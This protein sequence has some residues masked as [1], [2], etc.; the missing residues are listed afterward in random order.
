[1]AAPATNSTTRTTIIRRDAEGNVVD[2]HQSNSAADTA[3]KVQQNRTTEAPPKNATN[4][5]TREN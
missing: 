2:V 3:K 1:M 4:E 5:G